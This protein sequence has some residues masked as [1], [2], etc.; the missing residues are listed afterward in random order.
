MSTSKKQSQF[1]VLSSLS[2]ADY[3]TL[4]SNGANYKAT[5]SSLKSYLGVT[6][7]LDSVGA[8]LGTPILAEPT[9]NEYYIRKLEDGAGVMF[10]VSGD[11]IEVYLENNAD[12]VNII[13][14]NATV[15]IN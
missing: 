12:T 15:R 2:D 10:S 11:Y 8:T 9:A 4:I 3:F 6:G 1:T 5:L 7:S 14:K 13:G